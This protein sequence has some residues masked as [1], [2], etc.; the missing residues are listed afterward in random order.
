MKDYYKDCFEGRIYAIPRRIV[1]VH[2][3]GI[4]IT[5]GRG[6]ENQPVSNCFSNTLSSACPDCQE[7]WKR[8]HPW[9]MIVVSPAGESAGSTKTMCVQ[10]CPAINLYIT[11]TYS[12]C[13]ELWF[14]VSEM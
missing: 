2:N 10:N 6:Y 8:G 9:L 13:P 5:S 3:S 12:R 14:W 4:S 1:S 7:T 11:W